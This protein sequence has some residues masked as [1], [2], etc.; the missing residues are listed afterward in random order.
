MATVPSPFPSRWGF[1]PCDYETYRKL[2]LLNLL[3]Q[4]AIASRTPGTAGTG[5]TR[6]TGSPPSHA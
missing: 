6:T 1:H 3:Y 2:K 5:R 4:R